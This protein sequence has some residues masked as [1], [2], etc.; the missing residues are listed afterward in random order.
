M[1]FRCYT[2][3]RLTQKFSNLDHNSFILNLLLRS[4]SRLLRS[5]CSDETAVSAS[6]SIFAAV[7]HVGF[8]ITS[9]DCVTLSSIESQ[10]DLLWHQMILTSISERLIETA[11]LSGSPW[12]EQCCSMRTAAAHR[13]NRTNN[14]DGEYARR[15]LAIRVVGPTSEARRVSFLVS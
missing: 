13:C 14:S 8:Y 4:S 7:Q 11:L 1:R 12:D 3:C 5:N 2:R 15:R 10:G 9:T 6:A